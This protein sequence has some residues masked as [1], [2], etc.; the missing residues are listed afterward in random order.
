MKLSIRK[1]L[2][3]GL[4]SGVITTI[5]LIV[6]L[7]SSTSSKLAVIGGILS[8]AIADAFSDALGMHVSEESTLKKSNGSVWEST[9]AT[10]FAKFF[11]A[12]TFIVPFLIFT[13]S[14]A[15]IVSVAWAF[16]LIIIY[17]YSLAK[18]E[19]V[20]P[21]GVISQHLLI[22]IIVVII[23]YYLGKLVDFYFV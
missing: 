5:G 10:F 8:I 9:I 1:G 2:G 16:L 21:L 3:F 22:A 13:L 6:G 20:N 12:L 17:N 11:F 19:K 23:T 15:T 7:Y 18:R 14:T 4:T